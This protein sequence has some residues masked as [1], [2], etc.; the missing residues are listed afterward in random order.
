MNS[1]AVAP[2]TRRGRFHAEF[3]AILQRTR[4]SGCGAPDG[5]GKNAALPITMS[6]SH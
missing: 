4:F 2:I 3:S 1:L 6:R 5:C